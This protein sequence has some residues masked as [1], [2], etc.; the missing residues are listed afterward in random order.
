MKNAALSLIHVAFAEAKDALIEQKAAPRATN[1]A[2]HRHKASFL[3]QPA[4]LLNQKTA[5]LNRT[6]R[7]LM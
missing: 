7:R 4:A 3:S 1:D 6:D 5:L 2:F